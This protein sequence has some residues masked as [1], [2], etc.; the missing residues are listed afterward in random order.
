MQRLKAAAKGGAP[1]TPIIPTTVGDDGPGSAPASASPSEKRKRSRAPRTPISKKPKKD[2][3]A[4]VTPEAEEA[5]SNLK[6][7]AEVLTKCEKGTYADATDKDVVEET[8]DEL[9]EKELGE[10][11]VEEDI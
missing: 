7:M 6:D 10:D 11:E 1:L 9:A 4:E 5:S 8:E 2:K 3:S